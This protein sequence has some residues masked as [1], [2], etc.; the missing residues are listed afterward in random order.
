MSLAKRQNFR[1]Q[2]TVKVALKALRGDKI[3]EE[4]A[5]KHQ[6]Q[7]TQVSKCK[8]QAIEGMPDLCPGGTQDGP[9]DAEMKDLHA[10][11]GRVAIANDFLSEAP[12]RLALT[13]N[14][15]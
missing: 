11:I 1:D 2:F 15:R 3:M 5:A 7:T 4:I 6:L 8:R 10:K 9:T 12:K 13:R 14:A